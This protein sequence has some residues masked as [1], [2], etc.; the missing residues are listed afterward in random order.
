MQIAQIV[1]FVRYLLGNSGS[2]AV[3]NMYPLQYINGYNIFSA[4]DNVLHLDSVTMRMGLGKNFIF[5]VMIQV[6]LIVLFWLISFYFSKKVND[7]KLRGAE[8]TS[9]GMEELK[10]VMVM[11]YK[12]ATAAFIL[13]VYSF[14]IFAF[15]LLTSVQQN[16]EVKY[17]LPR[18]L[19]IFTLVIFFYGAMY[20]TAQMY[21]SWLPKYDED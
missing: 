7:L 14:Y 19:L 1:F 5:N 8:Q 3:Y 16:N 10:K 13:T 6:A 20:I 4:Y 9:L 21:L 18:L 12:M 11:E 17:D 2:M 15:A